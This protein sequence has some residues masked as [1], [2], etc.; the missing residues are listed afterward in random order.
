MNNQI[1]IRKPLGAK[2]DNAVSIV[3]VHC[4]KVASVNIIEGETKD[5]FNLFVL[6]K[7]NRIA[8]NIGDGDDHQRFF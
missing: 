3:F 7:E 1:G 2:R 6:C 5:R 8:V 4:F